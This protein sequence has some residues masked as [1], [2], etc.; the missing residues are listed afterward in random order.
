M[1]DIQNENSITLTWLNTTSI[2]A[3]YIPSNLRSNSGSTRLTLVLSPLSLLLDHRVFLDF[4]NRLRKRFAM[5]HEFILPVPTNAVFDPVNIVRDC[6]NIIHDVGTVGGDVGFVGHE[7]NIV[8]VVQEVDDI[9]DAVS[10]RVDGVRV[11]YRTQMG[12]GNEVGE[13]GEE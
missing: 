3:K 13:W 7:D 10:G 12:K 4:G 6:I 2:Q 8:Q 5:F 1:H 11:A 9:V